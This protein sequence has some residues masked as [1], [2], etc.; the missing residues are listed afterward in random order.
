MHTQPLFLPL[1]CV[2][3]EPYYGEDRLSQGKIIRAQCSISGTVS[4]P[5]S[6]TTSHNCVRSPATE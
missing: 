5:G 1:H 4:T 2:P 3:R 6:Y